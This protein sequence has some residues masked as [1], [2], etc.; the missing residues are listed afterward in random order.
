MTLYARI[1]AA[2]AQTQPRVVIGT[3][4]VAPLYAVGWVIGTLGRVVWGVL[5]WTWLAVKFGVTDGWSGRR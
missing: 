4:A 1:H 5:L 3:L 2:A